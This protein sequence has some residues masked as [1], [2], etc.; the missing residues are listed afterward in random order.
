[1]RFL[2]VENPERPFSYVGIFLGFA[3]SFMLAAKDEFFLPNFFFFG[4]ST[5]CYCLDFPIATATSN[6]RGAV[7]C[8]RNFIARI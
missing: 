7:L 5:C 8:L 3:V 6:S 1:M 4:E 2:K